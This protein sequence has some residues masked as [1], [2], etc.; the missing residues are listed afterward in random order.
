MDG[1]NRRMDETTD[2]WIDGLGGGRARPTGVEGR[3]GVGGA[4]DPIDGRRPTSQCRGCGSRRPSQP[5]FRE[6]MKPNKT[7]S[8]QEQ[9][10][11]NQVKSNQTISDQPKSNPIKSS[12]AKPTRIKTDQIKSN[13]FKSNQIKSNQI[14]SNQFKSA[15]RRMPRGR[16]VA[17]TPRSAQRRRILVSSETTGVRSCASCGPKGSKLPRGVSTVVGCC[18]S[19][20][21]PEELTDARP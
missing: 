16:T 21:A 1:W 11:T 4:I 3:T 6:Q 9:T 10:N 14:N 12:Q 13:R 15:S 18:A 7:N 19:P 20:R 8:E 17:V 2:E 5:P